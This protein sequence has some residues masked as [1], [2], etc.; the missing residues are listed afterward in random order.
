[1][2]KLERYA[3]ATR[4]QEKKKPKRG[5][6]TT[7]EIAKGMQV[8]VTTNVDTDLDIANGARGEITDIILHPDEPP[9]PDAPV[10][11]LTR[12][13]AY[14]LVKLKRTRATQLEG[15]EECVIPVEPIAMKFQI[16]VKIKGKKFITRTV[17]RKQFPITGAY[18]R[19][20]G[21]RSHWVLGQHPTGGAPAGRSAKLRCPI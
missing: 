1:M 15:L 19:R 6:A 21:T 17:T 3:A 2:T 8:M 11:K 13:P 12:L 4:G 16:K 9:L 20:S 18:H 14:L 5:L 10:V 7:I